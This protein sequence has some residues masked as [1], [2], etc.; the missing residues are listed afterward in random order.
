MTPS[1]TFWEALGVFT[2]LLGALAGGAAY[3]VKL[4]IANELARFENRF[5][6]K[7]NGRY[8][9]IKVAELL[10]ESGNVRHQ[11]LL[12]QIVNICPMMRDK[13]EGCP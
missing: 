6:D 9:G 3:Y 5:L 8:L 4:A 7:M 2:A 1:P 12:E 13:K 11:A 10:I